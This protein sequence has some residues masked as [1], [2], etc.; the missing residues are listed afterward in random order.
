MSLTP[1]DLNQIRGIVADVVEG[2]V[3]ASESSLRSEMTALRTELRTEMADMKTELKT[4][5]R[6]LREML[7]GDARGE[8]Q[9]LDRVDRR[10]LRTQRL[11]RG[12]MAS[13]NSHQQSAAA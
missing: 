8:S 6:Q 3:G 4:D 9:R 1:N 12:H 5:I 10:S 11:L 2:A 7:E 13:P